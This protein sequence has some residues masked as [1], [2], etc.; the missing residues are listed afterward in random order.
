MAEK[1]RKL[2]ILPLKDQRLV[3]FPGFP[4]IIDVGRPISI[5]AISAAKASNSTI[6]VAIQKD[7]R[8]D[9]PSAADFYGICTEAEIKSIVPLDDEGIKK[10]I[11]VIGVNRAR[12]KTVGK[13]SKGNL[14]Y[15]NGEILPYKE[16]P[17]EINEIVDENIAKIFRT[18]E[19]NFPYITV[20]N[21]SLPKTSKDLSILIDNIIGQ[22][23]LDGKTKLNF[24][25]EPDVKKRLEILI[26]VLGMLVKRTK[27]SPPI[28]SNI[29]N[30]EGEFS[31][32]RKL[33]NNS[34][35]PEDV[36]KI[37]NQELRRLKNM[38]S[39]M[40]EY[41]IT[42]NYIEALSIL[43][44][45]KKSEDKLDIDKARKSLDNDHYG[46]EKP[47]ERILEYL[48]VRKLVPNR[49]GAILCF[50]GPPGVGK[51]QPLDAKVLTP[52]GWKTMG[53]INVGDIVST[54][55]G[56]NANVICIYP[57]GEK[58]IY[59]VVFSDGSKTEC[60]KEHLWKVKN[61]D[62]RKEDKD[63][64]VKSLE[65]INKNLYVERG[66]RKNYSIPMVGP[67]INFI[68]PE[69]LGL[70]PYLVGA[71]LGDK[72]LGENKTSFTNSDAGLIN[73]IEE[74]LNLVRCKL[75][76]RGDKEIDYG[77]SKINHRCVN[78][79]NK[80]NNKSSVANFIDEV[81]LRGCLADKK[82]VPIQYKLTSSKNRLEL[83]RGILD[84][85]GSVNDEKHSIEYSSAS[86]QLCKDVKFLV[87]SLG[88]QAYYSSGKSFY[89][90]K[91]EKLQEKDRHRLNITLPNGIIP[92]KMESKINLYNTT[93][94]KARFL[95][96]YI[97]KIEYVGKKEAKCILIDHP[98]H[99]YI[100]DDFIVTHNTSLGKSIAKAMGREFIRL[101]LGGVHDEAEIRGHR[102]T[103]IGAMTGK[104]IQYLKKTGVNNPLYML[105]EIDKLSKDFRG[106]PGSAL[107]EVLD[108]EQNC[109]FVD[110]Y[111]NVPFDLSNVF[112]ITTANDI[113]PIPPALQDR[114]E[115]IEI[116]G[117]SPHDKLKIVQNYLIPKQKEANGLKEYDISI[118][119]QAITKVIEEYTG[120]A[121]VRNL[122]RECGAILRKIAVTV[123]AGKEA[124]SI[125]RADSISKFLGPPKV[126]IEK[127]GE[128][129][130]VGLSTGLAWSQHGGSLLFV[131]ASL[132]SGKGDIKLTGNLGKV[133]Q[134]S[135]STALTWIKSNVDKFGIDQN[136]FSQKD[137]H[138]HFPAGATPKDGP[139]A[140]IAI[141][142]AMLSLFTNKPVRNDVAMTGEITLR[143][144]VLPIGG[145]VEK[146]LAAHR[147][148][149]KEVLYPTQNQHN[150][151]EIP[152][153]VRNEIKLTPVSNLIEAID[154]LL[155]NIVVEEDSNDISVKK[156]RD[157]LINMAT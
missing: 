27:E 151:D 122:E 71:L 16:I 156:N 104:I 19:I 112:F 58:E 10:R 126:F 128:K 113:G 68:E 101:S 25:G 36:L 125:V 79:I 5:D 66:L 97:K 107:L 103:Y 72:T 15:L 136:L 21:K 146:V 44:W 94:N 89:T 111:L 75:S 24:L 137:V 84:T 120:E 134:E 4:C 87:E 39:A 93:K 119:P 143:G 48:A 106:D 31:R 29:E 110:N 6:V 43:P 147:G 115:I 8:V 18:I 108:P 109:A 96:R 88:G 82:F 86:I 152:Q 14:S 12:L 52:G 95:P 42:T 17:V 129:P 130:E 78:N 121:G 67:N 139:S 53:D 26:F 56:K 45:D 59:S 83:L 144:R 92:F 148:G 30:E 131:E 90:Y 116:P 140:G 150:I 132:C 64:C 114:M 9:E 91:G 133:L 54:P 98:D 62:D 145:L 1:G 61:R 80:Q 28:I 51:A 11:I 65:Q 127:A 69:V 77:I 46:L 157:T 149:I 22:I 138:I 124:P 55:D 81:E 155:L 73:I 47:K 20:K 153:D 118:S 105:D 50:V 23:E 74:K 40:S 135:A 7:E 99:L 117:Y 60:C 63:G 37:A 13:V 32:L 33:V 70:D 35:M 41:A 2:P 123:A 85:N 34:K 38:N 49:K 142:A 154:K 100:T 76:L 141:S 57:Q 102:K 3:A